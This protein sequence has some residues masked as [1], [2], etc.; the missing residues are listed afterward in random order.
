[1][2]V[3]V[4]RRHPN[5]DDRDIRPSSLDNPQQVLGVLGL[6]L[7]REA[8]VLEQ[9]RDA[10]PDV[11]RIVGD[12]DSHGI[13][14]TSTVP[15]PRSL[16]MRS[17]PSSADSRSARPPSPVP[18]DV[19]APPTPSSRTEIRSKPFGRS[20]YT[21]AYDAPACLATFVSASETKKYA[22]SSTVSGNRSP[23]WPSTSTGIEA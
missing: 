18:P 13:S 20:R 7:D 23:T 14:A 1:A 6:P 10:L 5:V 15:W 9:P 17:E 4:G 16:S 11:R 19:S 2:F 3:G 12:H 22:A 8:G 21:A